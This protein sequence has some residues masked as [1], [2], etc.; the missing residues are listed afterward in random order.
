MLALRDPDED[1][2]LLERHGIGAIEARMI[3]SFA[4]RMRRTIQSVQ[5]NISVIPTIKI[6]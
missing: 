5:A 3:V 4:R 2:E 1:A 6:D